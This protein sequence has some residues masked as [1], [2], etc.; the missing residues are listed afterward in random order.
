MPRPK[1]ILAPNAAAL[2]V[3][4]DDGHESFYPGP[5]LRKLCPCA[6]CKEGTGGPL[7]LVHGGE[8]P[9]HKILTFH[10]V[11]NYALGIAWGD[12]HKTGIYTFDYLRSICSCP[13]CKEKGD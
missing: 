9:R 1:E 5:M 10:P 13:A 6:E 2:A 8:D 3:L 11:G 4:W 12:G 7:A